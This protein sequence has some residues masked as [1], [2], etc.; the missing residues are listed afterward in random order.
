MKIALE[1]NKIHQQNADI[2]ANAANRKDVTTKFVR[3]IP[4]DEHSR[5]LHSRDDSAAY[6]EN[7]AKLT[8]A[9]D[10][11]CLP[12]VS[13]EHEDSRRDTIPQPTV[14]CLRTEH[15]SSK[16]QFDDHM[17]ELTAHSDGTL[18]CE[19]EVDHRLESCDC[20]SNVITS[21]QP[22]QHEKNRN[23]IQ[24]LNHDTPPANSVDEN[25][26][27]QTTHTTSIL[28][29]LPENSNENADFSDQ[30]FLTKQ[31]YACSQKSVNNEHSHTSVGVNY[32]KDE[33]LSQRSD[34]L[35]FSSNEVYNSM[36]D[37]SL[38]KSFF[39]NPT[40]KHTTQGLDNHGQ[41]NIQAIKTLDSQKQK[42]A[43]HT[44]QV[45]NQMELTN[46]RSLAGNPTPVNM[47]HGTDKR[48][49]EYTENNNQNVID[50]RRLSRSSNVN[51][52]RKTAANN[53]AAKSLLL[54]VIAY[55]ICMAPF[56]ITKLCKVR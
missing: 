39:S 27:I 19:K 28:L 16:V 42:F 1:H 33:T 29:Q 49:L 3:Q 15:D 9:H 14:R 48:I 50:K 32:R 36:I 43:D 22:N 7:T 5:S 37:T 31:T 34:N 8:N 56:S 10:T 38:T 41:S 2:Q 26:V 40:T 21:M 25:P 35:P 47:S 23:S 6:N 4:T 51:N 30:D 54:V 45:D 53:K 11:T 13:H 18:L 20:R 12:P 52:K 17:T 55:F 44:A 46:D 24:P